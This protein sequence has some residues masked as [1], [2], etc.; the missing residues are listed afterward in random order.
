MILWVGIGAG[1]G[2][3]VGGVFFYL[4]GKWVLGL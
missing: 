1:I 2:A 3:I 4:F